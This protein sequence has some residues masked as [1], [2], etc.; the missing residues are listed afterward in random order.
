M[1]KHKNILYMPT[2]SELGGIETYVYEMVKKY[3]DL[4]IAVV[5]K[6]CDPLQARRI[7]KY[8]PLYIHTNQQIECDVA[9]INYDISIIEYISKNAKIYETI[10]G[11]YSNPIYGGRKPLTHSRITGYIAITKYLQGRVQDL[12]GVDN[13]IMSY[14]PLTVEENKPFITLVSATRL[15]KNKG[16][17]RMKELIKALD[18]A[19]VDYIWYCITNDTEVI[20]HP[21]VIMIPNRLD[22]D[23]W[24][25]M[26]DYVVLLSD[27]EACSYTLNEALYRNIPIIATP[28]PYLEEIGVKDGKNGYI[29]DF[30]CKNVDEVARKIEKIPKFIFKQLEDN[31]R[32]IFA[33]SKSRYEEVKSMK[34]KV[35]A[36]LDFYDMED[37]EDKFKDLSG[38]NKDGTPKRES[39]HIWVVDKERADYLMEHNAVKIIEVLADEPK[40]KTG[41]E[42]KITKK[43]GK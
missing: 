23:K 15:H 26:A 34:V 19:K 12:L 21:K 7:R 29:I 22:V 5:S 1:I 35:E 33:K 38:Q 24:L 25:R 14:N 42:V 6:T 3:K 18:R 40:T 4:D 9:I 36:I 13:V 2:I 10:H 27:S 43:K 8:C 11:D 28:L 17:N 30:D 41:K 37:K 16:V 31:Y 32:N 20:K 39:Q